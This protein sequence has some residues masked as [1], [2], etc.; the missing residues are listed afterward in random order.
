MNLKH[1]AVLFLLLCCQVAALADGVKTAAP[2]V[3]EG[4]VAAPIKDVWAAFTT[5]EGLESWMA[6]HADI[7]VKIGGRMRTQY[8]PKGVIGDA[9]TIENEIISYE[10]ER[11]ISIRVAK[12]PAGFPFPNAVKTM[13]TVIYFEAASTQTTRLR[14]AGMGF[15]DDEES[16]KMRAFFER[17]NAYTL[18][19]L[20][21]RFA[22]P[23]T[24]K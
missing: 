23:K 14:I 8:D 12:A 7:E 18:K 20:Q 15:G 1:K 4:I 5:K 9:G 19:Q 21:A 16:K 22:A 13:W 17:G 6:A 2:L 3:H 24:D 11:M 10:P